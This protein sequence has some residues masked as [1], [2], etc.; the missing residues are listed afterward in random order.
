[1]ATKSDK[2]RAEGTGGASTEARAYPTAPD[3]AMADGAARRARN[4]RR[5]GIALLVVVVALALTGVLGQRTSTVSASGGGYLLSVTYPSVMRPGV[6]VRWNVVVTNPNGFGETLTIAMSRH[7]LD[8][9]DLNSLRP[10]ADSATSTGDAIVY[11]W[12]SPPGQVFV[13]ALDAYAEYGEHFG[14]NG[15]TSIEVQGRPVVTARYHTRWVP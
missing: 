7:Y 15:F 1:M 12:S 5:V 13:L 10:D 2:R 4:W 11:S 14:L 8:L 9:F 6:D 3:D